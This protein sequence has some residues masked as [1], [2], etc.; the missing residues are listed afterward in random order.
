MRR[1]MRAGFALSGGVSLALAGILLL[2]TGTPVFPAG[3]DR[4]V[5]AQVA[6]GEGSPGT[7]F[8]VDPAN[9]SQSGDG[10]LSS[11]FKDLNALLDPRAGFLATNVNAAGRGG[12]DLRPANPD[13]KIRPGSTIMLLGGDYGKLSIANVYNDAYLTIRAAPGAEARF[14]EITI[15]AG[16]MF[17][18]DGVMLRYSDARRIAAPV[19]AMLFAARGSALGPVSDIVLENASLATVSDNALFGDN[20]WKNLSTDGVNLTDVTCVQ[21]LNNRISNVRRG[22]SNGARHATVSG[23]TISDF[24]GDGIRFIASDQVYTGNIIRSSRNTLTDT[25]HPDGMQGFA[26]EPGKELKDSVATDITINGNIIDDPIRSGYDPIQGISYFDGIFRNVA[27]FNNLVRTNSVHGISAYGGDNILIAHNTVVSP[28]AGDEGYTT[29]K[30]IASKT[31]VLPTNAAV[32][33]NVTDRLQ[34]ADGVKVLGNALLRTKYAKHALG[35]IMLEG[36]PGSWFVGP[37]T[38]DFTPRPGSPLVDAGTDEDVAVTTDLL[39][40]ARHGKP[41]IG[42]FEH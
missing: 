13:G 22:I 17:V 25:D 30:L 42:A 31:G 34:V 1:L 3:A 35:S 19:K 7:V 29:I 2:A 27:I 8:Y 37:A 39:G 5:C 38:G 20:D 4:D 9:G 32:L 28:A 40:K 11:P 18:F 10:S 6:M 33:N 16:R 36:D 21:L 24:S 23:N 14:S 41:D 15:R 12:F 26:H